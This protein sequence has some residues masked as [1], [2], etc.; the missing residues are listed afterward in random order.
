M[1]LWIILVRL[2]EYFLGRLRG[3]GEFT[4]YRAHAKQI[5]PPSVLLPAPDST[6]PSTETLEKI[7]HECSLRSELKPDFAV[8]PLALSERGAPITLVLEY[9]GETLDGY[10]EAMEIKQF[11][12][13]A[14]GF[15]TTLEA[16]HERELIHKGV[17]PTNVLA[18]SSTD[19]AGLMDFGIASRLWREHQ[20]PNLQGSSPE[21]CLTWLLNELG[22]RIARSTREATCMPSTAHFTRCS[23][24]TCRLQ[25]PIRL[26][27]YIATSRDIR[28]RLTIER[29]VCRH[30]SLRS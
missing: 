23:T 4:L 30:V 3:D 14:V 10:L 6:R 11:L 19:Q 21:Q 13:L 27:G 17:K 22:E 20:A 15:T 28:C 16:L 2:S 25:L 18:H 8:R 12:G 26:N 7:D 5:E 24:A 29:R 1:M 9:P